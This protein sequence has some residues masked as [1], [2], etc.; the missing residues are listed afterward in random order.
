[1]ISLF[2]EI[3]TKD[4]FIR[5]KENSVKEFC[6]NH[7][8]PRSL[9]HEIRNYLLDNDSKQN[10]Y[11]SYDKVVQD[12]RDLTQGL[13]FEL[14]QKIYYDIFKHKLKLIPLFSEVKSEKFMVFLCSLIDIK[15]M[16]MNEIVYKPGDIAKEIYVV[17]KGEVIMYNSLL[18]KNFEEYCLKKIPSFTIK[19]KRTNVERRLYSQEKSKVM[20]YF[21]LYDVFGENDIWKNDGMTRK[22]T[23][24]A[25]LNS[26]LVML[27]KSDIKFLFEI[28][29]NFKKRVSLILENNDYYYTY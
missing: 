15:Y 3:S 9:Y 2:E 14:N 24:K 16:N 18:I 27:R 1:M 20:T 17:F 21:S 19:T 25:K 23:V 10:S 11:F 5:E 22:F 6:R 4:N 7:S 29:P 12:F 13:P 26:V 28:D 8:L